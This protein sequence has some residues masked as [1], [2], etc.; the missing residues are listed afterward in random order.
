MV[1]A[2]R[3][4]LTSENK[5]AGFSPSADGSLDFGKVKTHRRDL[6]FPIP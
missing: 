5:S 1:K 4:E 6:N 3:V 2:V